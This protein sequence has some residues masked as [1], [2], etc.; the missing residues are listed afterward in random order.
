MDLQNL[1]PRETS[2]G[3]P[4]FVESEK[5]FATIYYRRRRGRPKPVKIRRS[6]SRDLFLVE[7]TI[8]ACEGTRTRP[9][10]LEIANSSESLAKLF[11]ELLRQ[12]GISRFVTLRIHAPIEGYE[13]YRRHWKKMLGIDRFEKPI[14]P[15]SRGREIKSG[16]IHIRIYRAVIRELFLHWARI[17]PQLLQ[18]SYDADSHL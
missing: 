12:I 8:W 16:I 15:E 6:I 4:I 2:R 17:L 10:E 1:I 13:R 14:T 7:V 18:I 11:L 9:Y 5:Q 3:D